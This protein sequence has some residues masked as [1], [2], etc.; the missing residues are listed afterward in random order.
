MPEPLHAPDQ[1]DHTNILTTLPMQ[2]GDWAVK[3]EANTLT[4]DLSQRQPP[5]PRNSIIYDTVNPLK[6][7]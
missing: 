7:Q 1:S 2:R 5:Y 4:G 6:C 3:S